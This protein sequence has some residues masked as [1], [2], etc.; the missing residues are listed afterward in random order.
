MKIIFCST[1]FT[2]IDEN[3]KNSKSP[4]SV[5]GHKY[6]FNIIKGQIGRAHV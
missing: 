2:E 6:Q 3:I 4:N 5:S 1:M